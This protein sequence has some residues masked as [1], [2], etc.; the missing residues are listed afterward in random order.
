MSKRQ[1]VLS[2]VDGS[3]MEVQTTRV[4]RSGR[5]SR[6]P[7][8]RGNT[9]TPKR[10]TRR[11]RKSVVQELTAADEK[12]GEQTPEGLLDREAEVSAHPGPFAVSEAAAESTTDL[13]GNGAMDLPGTTATETPPSSV[14]SVPKKKSLLAPSRTQKT[15]IP[16]G[17]PKSG[18]VWKD[19]NKKR[20][21]SVVRDKQLCTSWE[22]KMQAKQEKLLVKQYSLQLKEEKAKQKEDK[23]KR[24]EENLKRRAENERKAE[25]VQVIKNTAK[26]KRMKKKHL[27]KIE[28]RDTLALMQ[29]ST[30]QN[31]KTKAR[32]K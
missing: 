30:T 9:E 21:S 17:K 27:R 20:F 3:E 19:R 29:N 13:N 2:E 31:A 32:K 7:P 22:K 8:E 14:E 26:I 15:V 4:T 1:K 18:R 10:T 24:R 11:T 16:L 25:I 12:N 6:P 28:K 5:I 23:R